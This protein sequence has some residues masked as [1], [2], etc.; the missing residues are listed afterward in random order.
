VF[1]DGG[2]FM[3]RLFGYFCF[4]LFLLI[5]SLSCDSSE[6]LINNG[7]KLTLAVE[8]S[9]CTEVWLK[10]TTTNIPLPVT[11]SLEQ[12]NTTI[13]TLS[14]TSADTLL[15]V[16]GLL[17][18]QTYSFRLSSILNPV[19]GIKSN[20]LTITTMDT[21]SHNFTWQ[22][23]EFGEPTGN[24][25][26]DVNIIDENNIWTVGAI[27]MNDS[28]GNPD[29]NAY[30]A[31][32]WDGSEWELKRIMF[33][34]ICGQQNLSSYPARSIQIF[35]END[36]W[37]GVDGDQISRI[38]NGVQT[39]TI[40]LPWSF[41]INKLWGTSSDDLYVI[42]NEGN[43]AHYSN[44]Q[45]GKIESG[46]D[47]TLLD[48]WAGNDDKLYISGAN[49]SE[50]KGILLTIDQL[51]KVE[52]LVES[53]IVSENQ[54]FRPKLYGELATVWIDNHNNI[55]TGGNLI[56]RQK[57][58][59]WDYLRS[60]P[61]NYIG[62]NP[63]V[64]YR[65]FVNRVRGNSSNDFW[66]VGERNTLRHFNGVSWVQIGLSYDPSSPITWKSVDVKD[67]LVVVVGNNGLHGVI[68]MIQR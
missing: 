51:N 2:A 8:D 41:S 30:N 7:A 39:T 55:Y 53:E 63:N 56:F 16:D 46:T 21:T 66:I 45:W 32:H 44:G 17:P 37:I 62:G 22:S 14:I 54:L 4:A 11:L 52:T 61:E 42:G 49:S 47:L 67:D 24:Q 50:A 34:T 38:E 27:Y 58:G 20:E 12:N 57:S 1:F 40:C 29:P 25:I 10:L 59:V 19:S 6:P 3:V 5:T 64:Y 26:Y 35:N 68:M 36:I 15:Y 18:K 33:Y 31:V 23:F 43:I 65:G 9:S 13:D 60:L 28:L 48:I